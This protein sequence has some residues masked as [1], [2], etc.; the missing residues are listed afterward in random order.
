[1]PSL[2]SPSYYPH[3]ALHPGICQPVFVILTLLARNGLGSCCGTNISLFVYWVIMA[4]FG[5]KQM[6]LILRTLICLLHY[7]A[8]EC[9]IFNCL[10]LSLIFHAQVSVKALYL[11]DKDRISLQVHIFV[12]LKKITP[13]QFQFNFSSV[14]CHC[15]S[16]YYWTHVYLLIQRSWYWIIFIVKCYHK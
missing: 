11:L 2:L 14:E 4:S 9:H 10:L 13:G 6:C 1:M 15:A 7:P 5:L 8:C 16:R 3:W 12:P